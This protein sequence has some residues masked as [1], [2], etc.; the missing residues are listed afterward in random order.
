VDFTES[1]VL[2][3]ECMKLYLI[4]INNNVRTAGIAIQYDDLMRRGAH[5]GLPLFL[6]RPDPLAHD[7]SF[8]R[9]IRTSNVD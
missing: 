3:R 7:L 9:A 5:T 8:P 4:Y 6:A 1:L 2:S